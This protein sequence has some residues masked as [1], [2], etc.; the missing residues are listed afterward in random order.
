MLNT[1]GVYQADINRISPNLARPYRFMMSEYDYNTCPIFLAIEGHYAEMYGAKT[2]PD[3]I[4]LEF[5]IPDALVK[6]QD[7]YDWTD[8][9]FFM[10]YPEEYST[11]KNDV[12]EYARQVLH[13][14]EFEQ[15]RALQA[16]VSE[17]RQEWLIDTLPCPDLLIKKHVGSGGRDILQS[18]H[19]YAPK[20]I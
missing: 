14:N 11:N 3:C 17:L 16:T 12:Y 5:D 1:T 19:N 8:V 6:K 7:Y 2:K 10:E 18:L 15:K 13:Q 20:N 9:I 4:A